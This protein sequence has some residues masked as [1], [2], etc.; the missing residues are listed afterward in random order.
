MGQP[1]NNDYTPPLPFEGFAEALLR[2]FEIA[3]PE[4]ERFL[5]P[6]DLDQFLSEQ[7]LSAPPAGRRDVRTVQALREELRTLFDETRDE[8]E[9]IEQLN[10]MLSRSPVTLTLLPGAA[11]A[12]SATH[13]ESLVQRVQ[14]ASAVNLA[15][16][17]ARYGFSRLRVCAAD[18]CRD[19]FIDTSKKG[20][21][22]FCGNRCANRW[23][24]ATFRERKKRDGPAN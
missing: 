2:T 24:V 22:R 4:P 8:K 3:L 10:G 16:A 21:R 13:S 19:A 11:L 20:A 15:S 7:R 12:L 18:P 9:R 14:T 17:I 23:H 1:D 6:D 5:T